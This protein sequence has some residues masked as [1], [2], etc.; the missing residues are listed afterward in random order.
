MAD[1]KNCKSCG[2]E[3]AKSAKVCPHC[4]AKQK[5]KGGIIAIVVVVLIVVIALAASGG[6]DKDSSKV[7]NSAAVE[8]ND[9]A[10]DTSAAKNDETNTDTS[11]DEESTD[12]SSDEKDNIVKVGGS[13]EDNGI[14]FTVDSAELSF[15]ITDDD[16]GLYQLDEGYHYIKVDFTFENTGDSSDE[17]VS[18]Y[19]FDCYADNSACEQQYVTS[20]TGDFINTNL[21]PGRN[22]S[23]STLYAVPDGAQKIELE[24]TANIWTN[25]KVIVELN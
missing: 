1:M 22:V 4:G 24:Y 8:K 25:E 18:I 9:A 5:G 11:S 12:T 7:D 3:I 17:Y 21:S 20:V 13:F 23:F 16:Y 14:K 2:N 15:E 10:D 19:D 6:E